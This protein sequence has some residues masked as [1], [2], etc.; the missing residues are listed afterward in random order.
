MLGQNLRKRRRIL[1]EALEQT[2]DFKNIFERSRRSAK[3]K[4]QPRKKR[5]CVPKE[6]VLVL[7]NGIAIACPTPVT[8]YAELML[9]GI[10]QS[11]PAS[12]FGPSCSVVRSKSPHIP[13]A[14]DLNREPGGVAKTLRSVPHLDEGDWVRVFWPTKMSWFR[15]QVKD[16]SPCIVVCYEDGEKEWLC[17]QSVFRL[18]K[19]FLKRT[20]DIVPSNVG[21]GELEKPQVIPT[22]WSAFGWN[23]NES[24][25]IKDVFDKTIHILNRSDYSWTTGVVRD[26]HLETGYLLVDVKCQRGKHSEHWVDP[27]VNECY[28]SEDNGKK[29]KKRDPNVRRGPRLKGI[30]RLSLAR[31]KSASTP[32]TPKGRKH[33]ANLR[34]RKIIRNGVRIELPKPVHELPEPE[35]SPPLPALHSIRIVT[36][37][38]KKKKI[39]VKKEKD[40]SK[41]K[42]K[43]KRKKKKNQ[44]VEFIP[45]SQK[46]NNDFTST[47][48]KAFVQHAQM[49]N[50]R[51]PAV[52]MMSRSLMIPQFKV[53]PGYHQN[54]S[55]PVS[56]EDCVFESNYNSKQ[57]SWGDDRDPESKYYGVYKQNDNGQISWGFKLKV[58]PYYRLQEA[59][60]SSSKA[61]AYARDKAI[62]MSMNTC[63]DNVELHQMAFNFPQHKELLIKQMAR[64][65]NSRSHPNRIYLARHD[66]KS[67]FR[68]IQ[69]PARGPP[70]MS[71]PKSNHSRTQANSRTANLDSREAP[72]YQNLAPGKAYGKK[73]RKTLSPQLDLLMQ[74]GTFCH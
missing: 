9:D 59:G 55:S 8:H 6:N 16:L 2:V 25:I 35:Q 18:E 66:L 54:A 14:Y 48:P 49:D 40:D 23:D 46:Y 10:L 58:S 17:P 53:K 71:L 37:S 65:P 34:A 11:E 36:S 27:S 42:K 15:A 74:P 30:R 63:P 73:K 20:G 32:K 41:I 44:F 43:R 62:L 4:Y 3:G 52:H 61:A 64:D 7:D 56:K 67:P 22:V 70:E 19:E 47:P 51:P 39:K 29:W 57:D 33:W 60:F 31:K 72:V 28:I 13:I 24:G 50:S 45:P 5:R 12:F 38:K 68:P 69:H 1:E 26:T 21:Y